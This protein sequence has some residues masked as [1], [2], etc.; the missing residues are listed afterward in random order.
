M[1][2][3]S[4]QVEAELVLAAWR[5]RKGIQTP[6]PSPITIKLF[7]PL[8]DKQRRFSLGPI[9]ADFMG[10]PADQLSRM[11][12]LQSTSCP[13]VGPWISLPRSLPSEASR[14]PHGTLFPHSF[15]V[16][17]PQGQEPLV[18]HRTPNIFLVFCCVRY[19]SDNHLAFTLWV[20]YSV[21][22]PLDPSCCSR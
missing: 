14:A 15:S 9:A 21:P 3:P 5:F 8:I 17:Q 4:A 11:Y 16:F 1:P 7:L 12:S 13:A 18:R 22:L 20:C 10:I 6:P 19:K 2:A